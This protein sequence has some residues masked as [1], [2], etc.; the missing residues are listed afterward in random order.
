MATKTKSPKM[1]PPTMADAQLAIQL[2]EL[3]REEEMRKARNFV[4]FEFWPKTAEEYV[5]LA[6]ARDQRNAWM[7]QVG[8]YWEM[9]ASLVL[10]GLLHPDIFLDWCGEAFFT[11]SKFKPLLPEV[12]KQTG[13]GFMNVEKLAQTYPAMAERVRMLE[14]RIAQRFPQSAQ[15]AGKR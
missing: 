9:A 10:R 5:A 6:T 2:Y 11:Y 13:G 8:S 12:R 7:R 14:E 15:A 3:R 4:N 1:R